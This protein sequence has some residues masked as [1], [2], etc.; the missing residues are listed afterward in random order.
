MPTTG[1]SRWARTIADLAGAEQIEAAHVAEAIRYR[2]LV[3]SREKLL[4]IDVGVELGYPRTAGHEKSGR[5]RSGSATLILD[6]QDK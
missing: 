6:G 4:Y 1:S 2:A 5:R 3:F